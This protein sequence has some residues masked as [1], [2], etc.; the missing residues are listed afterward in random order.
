MRYIWYHCGAWL[1][2]KLYHMAVGY[3]TLPLFLWVTLLKQYWPFKSDVWFSLWKVL[4]FPAIGINPTTWYMLVLPFCYWNCPYSR[5]H[6]DSDISTIA[7]QQE[8]SGFI[9]GPSPSFVWVLFPKKNNLVRVEF[10]H[11][12]SSRL[13]LYWSKWERSTLSHLQG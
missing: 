13:W 5:W 4:V 1:Y 9:Y 11:C 3:R 2:C 7:P 6:I 8:D 10:P 12:C